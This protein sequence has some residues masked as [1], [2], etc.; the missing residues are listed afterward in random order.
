MARVRL[1]PAGVRAMLKSAEV[2][3]PLDAHAERLAQ[4][5]GSGYTSQ[6]WPWTTRGRASVSTDTFA[7]MRDNAKNQTLVRTLGT[8]GKS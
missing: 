1:N 7:A 8:G 4:S 5:A 3:A 6:P 2:Q